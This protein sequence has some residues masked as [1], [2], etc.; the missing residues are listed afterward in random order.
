[1]VEFEA[2]AEGRCAQSGWAAEGFSQQAGRVVHSGR[3]REM[4]RPGQ[5]GT[6]GSHK[7]KALGIRQNRGQPDASETGDHEQVH[8]FA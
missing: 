6:C 1:M 3:L 8:E 5:F 2:G 4:G 7:A